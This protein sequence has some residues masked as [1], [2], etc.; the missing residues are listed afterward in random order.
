MGCG[1]SSKVR[2]RKPVQP[3]VSSPLP[4]RSNAKGNTSEAD[5][6]E[7]SAVLASLGLEASLPGLRALGASSVNDVA[8]LLVS[9]LEE[10][11]L[12]RVQVRQLQRVVTLAVHRPQQDTPEAGGPREAV[13]G[14]SLPCRPPVSEQTNVVTGGGQRT[15]VTAII[16]QEIAVVSAR[17]QNSRQSATGASRGTPARSATGGATPGY[18]PSVDDQELFAMVSTQSSYIS[19]PAAGDRQVHDN[20][21]TLPRPAETLEGTF[22][23]D[24]TMLPGTTP[25]AQQ[26]SQPDRWRQQQQQLPTHQVPSE[27]DA[28]PQ[29][30]TGDQ[31][32]AAHGPVARS[33]SA[34]EQSAGASM[35]TPSVPTTNVQEEAS[36]AWATSL[37][38]GRNS[39]PDRRGSSRDAGG[40]VGRGR[41][42]SAD[43]MEEEEQDGPGPNSEPESW[44]AIMLRQQPEL[45]HGAPVG[46]QFPEALRRR[47]EQRGRG[48]GAGRPQVVQ[49]GPYQQG[50]TP[51]STGSSASG[52]RPCGQVA[53]PQNSDAEAAP[54]LPITRRSCSTDTPVQGRTRAQQLSDRDRAKSLGSPTHDKGHR[55][56]FDKNAL[57]RAHRDL[58]R[59]GIKRYRQQAR[60]E[61]SEGGAEG[62]DLAV[63]T[64]RPS[65]D[66]VQVYV[67]KRPLFDHEETERNE[68]DVVTVVPGQPLP[69]Q[70]VLHN[71]LFQA[72]LKTPLLNHLHF[73]FDHVFREGAQ[74]HEV[75]RVAA[76]ELVRNAIEGGASTMFMFGQT[77]SGKT[78]TMTA[79]EGLAARDLFQGAECGAGPCLAVQFVELCGNRCFDLL[80]ANASPPAGAK[81]R[82]RDK[83]TPPRPE[84]RLR[85]HTNGCYAAEGAV[86]LQP[87]SAE[88]LVSIMQ[89]AHARRATSATD[90]NSVSSRSHAICSLRLLHSAG[91]L[92]LADCAGTERR[93]DSMYHSKERQQE[94]AE[95]N[96][97]LH[98]LK[99]CVRLASGRQGV[100]PHAFR[101]SALTKLLSGAFCHSQGALLAAIC[102]VSP[103]AQDTEHT[104]ATLRT[105]LALAGRGAER[106]EK[107]A[108][109]VPQEPRDPH[110]KQWNP[111]QVSAW[112]AQAGGGR[113]G[114]A[115]SA[116]PSNFTGQMLVRLPESRCV[117]LC[118]GN[119]RRGR[120]LFELLH[121]EIRRA[122]QSRRPPSMSP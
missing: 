9:D 109:Q 104:L 16:E 58:F 90:A 8:E 117:Q 86:E 121:Q 70:L 93:K 116:L 40:R 110:P 39:L 44:R 60:L 55:Q 1:A 64:I 92:L 15:E 113:F 20:E 21:P 37:R 68:F 49:Q 97:S 23:F 25:T 27:P 32:H 18:S 57:R 47:L 2:G 99:E 62:P 46:E 77:G 69:K 103:C 122:E 26:A 96:A 91:R 17:S 111:E 4:A 14:R 30:P 76:S 79:I 107:E 71:C 63:C 61:S 59:A 94:G 29:L 3:T 112:I 33:P 36:I 28:E 5:V 24:V 38:G 34:A 114:D 67:R 41:S 119:D 7:L 19:G 56:M 85:E 105:G 84:L 35:A 43:R 51:P 13:S 102:T 72:D 88:E 31:M 52:K 78:H 42:S 87:K 6:K 74:D 11:G 50:I 89:A 81:E 106:E 65:E 10:A 53:V 12:T 48:A 98:A 101:A 45:A 108:L 80:T 115:R 100:P 118:G 75:Y 83:Q 66:N 54:L 22:H 82:H 73:D 120:Q 95:I